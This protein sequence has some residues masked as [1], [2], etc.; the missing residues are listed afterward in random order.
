MLNSIEKKQVAN[1]K[2]LALSKLVKHGIDDSF[3]V[4]MKEPVNEKWVA[5]YRAKSQFSGKPIFWLSKSLLDMPEEFVISVLHEYGHVIAE[6]A[7]VRSPALQEL[8]RSNWKGQFLM[9]P[10]DEEDFAEEFAQ[11]L[12]GNFTYSKDALDAVIH[13][14]TKEFES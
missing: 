11:Y 13:Q 2:S 6:Y 12:A 1:L 3:T 5:C 7:W 10:W 4:K 9:R 14:F 8:I